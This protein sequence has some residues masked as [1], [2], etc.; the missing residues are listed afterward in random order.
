MG[1]NCAKEMTITNSSLNR[2]DVHDYFSNI[3]IENST[4]YDWGITVG[5]GTGILSISNC[6]FINYSTPNFGGQTLVNINNSYGYLFDGTVIIKDC[7][8]IKDNINISIMKIDYISKT[9]VPRAKLKIP[10]LI[11]ENLKVR[12]ISK[13]AGVSANDWGS[14]I[15]VFYFIKR[16]NSCPAGKSEKQARLHNPMICSG[17]LFSYTA[18]LFYKG[19]T[20]FSFRFYKSRLK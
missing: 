19:F 2:I 7:E 13:K 6:K 10:N 1:T 8:V 4:L 20:F 5:C 15:P 18:Q 14:G 12:N 17:K 3:Y 16:G 11:V 9:G